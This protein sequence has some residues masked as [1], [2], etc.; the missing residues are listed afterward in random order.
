MA[1]LVAW[2]EDGQLVAPGD[3]AGQVAQVYGNV[4]K[5]LA[6]AGATFHDV[7]RFA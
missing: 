4:A 1:G 3:L 7:V 6:A 5:T 2:D